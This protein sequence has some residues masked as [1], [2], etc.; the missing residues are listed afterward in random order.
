[1]F[2]MEFDH[3]ALESLPLP[4]EEGMSRILQILRTICMARIMPYFRNRR[5][6]DP[7]VIAR[8]SACLTIQRW[9]DENSL[10]PFV[11]QICL[12]QE[13]WILLIHERIFDYLCFV[14]PSDPDVR[15][16]GKTPEEGKMLA[17]TEFLLRHQIEHLLYPQ[18]TQREVI[19]SDLVFAMERRLNDPTFY[20]MLRAALSDEMNGLRGSCYLD[21]FDA[22]EQDRPHDHMVAKVLS[23]YAARLSEMPDEL[24]QRLFPTL[25]M[26]LKTK[27]L[28]ECYRKSRNTTYSLKRRSNYLERVMR[29][30]V[31]AIEQ[32]EKGAREVFHSFMDRWG[33]GR[34]SP[35]IPDQDLYPRAGR[36]GTGADHTY[37]FPADLPKGDPGPGTPGCEDYQDQDKGIP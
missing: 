6:A 7:T 28:E 14:I 21:L 24:L 15:L 1:M 25:K 18:K 29:L 33:T 27:L 4:D 37:A 16:G 26:D 5:V 23:A 10:V 12:E 2:P 35:E 13:R 32:D 20:R 9:E 11:S 19:A 36:A 30:F 8:I 22:A 34:G 17:F 3:K 31:A